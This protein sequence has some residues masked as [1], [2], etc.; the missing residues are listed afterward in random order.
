MSFILDALKKS[1][2][3][4]QGQRGLGVA[5]VPVARDAPRAP[6]W[7]WWLLG[8]LGVNLVVLLAVL[9]RPAPD[10]T[11]GQG[12]AAPVGMAADPPADTAREP[13]PATVPERVAPELAAVVDRA[14]TQRESSASRDAAAGDGGEAPMRTD[15]PVS[16]P[17]EAEPVAVTRADTPAPARQP[18]P[19]S[20]PAADQTGNPAE[21][22]RATAAETSGAAPGTA[23]PAAG[24]EGEA[25]ALPTLDE[26]RVQG[27]MA[28]PDLHLDIH[29]WNEQPRGRFVY[30]NTMKYREGDELAEGPRVASIVRAGVVLEQ[31]G[32]RFLL[33]RE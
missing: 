4:R 3:E 15:P 9:L 11:P 29:V 25:L 12:S 18:E 22:S 31:A 5:D 30:V 27:E 1:E 33:P 20:G 32:R 8:L 10:P 24:T 7:M 13:R 17:A 19:A 14:R 28:L 26:L 2:N 6:V 23:E 21:T 16:G